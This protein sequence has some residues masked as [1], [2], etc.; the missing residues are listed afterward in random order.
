MI[1]I[2]ALQLAYSKAEKKIAGTI[3]KSSKV[4]SG[5]YC[6]SDHTGRLWKVYQLTAELDNNWIAVDWYNDYGS[7]TDPMPTK[8]HILESLGF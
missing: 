7:Y 3:C 8:R 6:V 5:V 4:H 1:D 2:K